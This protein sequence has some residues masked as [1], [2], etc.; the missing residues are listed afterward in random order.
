MKHISWNYKGYDD[1]NL[2]VEFP[3]IQDFWNATILAALNDAFGEVDVPK[4]VFVSRRY[5][6]IFESMAPYDKDTKT[7]FNTRLIPLDIDTPKLYVTEIH[8]DLFMAIE[9]DNHGSVVITNCDL[10][11]YVKEY[12]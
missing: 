1:L 11:A 5:L 3:P 7:I 9:H 12:K 2:G 8:V 10:P 4:N 6:P